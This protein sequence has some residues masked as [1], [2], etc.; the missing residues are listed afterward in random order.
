MTVG[1]HDVTLGDLSLDLLQAVR[2]G[3]SG[4]VGDLPLAR[5]MVQVHDVVRVMLPTVSAWAGHL[6]FTNEGVDCLPSGSAICRYS[7][8]DHLPVGFSVACLCSEV[9]R[10]TLRVGG[11]LLAIPATR[12][13]A[14]ITLASFA[15][16]GD[17]SVGG[18]RWCHATTL[19]DAGWVVA[20]HG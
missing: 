20:A 6:H 12:L 14:W 5:T 2:P 16:P 3:H 7:G 8:A 19:H 18:S 9:L 11:S 10:V 17:G 13:L 4:D 15:V 1:A